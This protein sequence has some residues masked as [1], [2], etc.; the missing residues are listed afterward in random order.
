MHVNKAFP[1]KS[2][3]QDSKSVLKMSKYDKLQTYLDYLEYRNMDKEKG[4]L[5]WVHASREWYELDST[6]SD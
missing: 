6:I 1:T 4:N 5:L 2:L 3:F